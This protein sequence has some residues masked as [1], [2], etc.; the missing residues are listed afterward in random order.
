MVGMHAWSHDGLNWTL[1]TPKAAYNK[2]VLW[3]DGSNTT[4]AERERPVLL[5]MGA[6]AKGVPTHLLNGV[7]PSSDGGGGGVGSFPNAPTH[8][9]I[10]P[11]IVE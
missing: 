1:G 10:I 4:F 2:T 5:F 7:R 8:T 9:I 6:G 11:L 3:A